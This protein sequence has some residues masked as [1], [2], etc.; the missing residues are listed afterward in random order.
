MY[1]IYIEKL[2]AITFM[3]LNQEKI[4]ILPIVEV[5]YH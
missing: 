2:L 1:E 3:I 5:E 4:I